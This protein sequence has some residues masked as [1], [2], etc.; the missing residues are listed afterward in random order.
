MIV[1]YSPTTGQQVS[2][3]SC[4]YYYYSWIH[5]TD[6]LCYLLFGFH[7]LI[8]IAHQYGTAISGHYFAYRAQAMK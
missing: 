3:I 8:F 5:I 4:E 7:D 2:V 1:D 6:F